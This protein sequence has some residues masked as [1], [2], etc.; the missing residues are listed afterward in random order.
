[1][2]SQNFYFPYKHETARFLVLTLLHNWERTRK[3]ETPKE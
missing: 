1:M 2:Q 3:K